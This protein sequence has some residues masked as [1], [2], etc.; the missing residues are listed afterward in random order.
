MNEREIIAKLVDKIVA[1]IVSN[2]KKSGYP[3]FAFYAAEG[4]FEIEIRI[5]PFIPPTILKHYRDLNSALKASPSIQVIELPHEFQKNGLFS[6]LINE[7]LSVENVD[8]VCISNV[9]NE[10]FLQYLRTSKSWRLLKENDRLF[11][12]SFYYESS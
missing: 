4:D 2:F 6:K 7:L 12:N 5:P 9:S 11:E 10:S 1:S 8:R 3:Q